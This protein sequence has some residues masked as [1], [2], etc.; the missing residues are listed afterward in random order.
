MTCAALECPANGLRCPRAH[1]CGFLCV[2]VHAEMYPRCCIQLDIVCSDRGLM[3]SGMNMQP[4]IYPPALDGVRVLPC[5][6][7]ENNVTNILPCI[8]VGHRPRRGG[9]EARGL[10]QRAHGDSAA[11]AEPD[12]HPG[13]PA[14]CPVF[15]DLTLGPSGVCYMLASF[16]GSSSL[17]DPKRRGVKPAFHGWRL[18]GQGQLLSLFSS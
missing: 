8:L 7:V 18:I 17:Q 16:L 4:F 14:Q 13:G 15:T 12:P 3:F 1:A 6:A 10:R 2:P 9:I 11:G 5:L